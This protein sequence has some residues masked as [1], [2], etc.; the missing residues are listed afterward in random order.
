MKLQYWLGRV[1]VF[2]L[3][4]LYFLFI[5]LMGYRVRGLKALRAMCAREFERHEGP[6]IV[7][8]NHLTMVDSMIIAYGMFSLPRHFTDFR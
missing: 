4:P 5:R 7:C 1:G 2:I 6:W 8:A 3:A